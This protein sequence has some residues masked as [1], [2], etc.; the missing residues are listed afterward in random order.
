MKNITISDNEIKYYIDKGKP[1]VFKDS[2]ISRELED[3]LVDV[4]ARILSHL[5]KEK[6]S[7]SLGYCLRELVN[8][9]KKA[10]LKRVFFLDQNLDIN[11]KTHY[12]KGMSLFKEKAFSNLDYYLDLMEEKEY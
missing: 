6:I 5:G 8:N 7:D 9:S 1:I 12:D 10:N 2:K 4:L 3:G 11:D